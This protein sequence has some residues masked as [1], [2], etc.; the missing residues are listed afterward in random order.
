MKKISNLYNFLVFGGAL[1]IAGAIAAGPIGTGIGDYVISNQV[2]GDTLVKRKG[3]CE[4]SFRA[5]SIEPTP[6]MMNG[7]MLEKKRGFESASNAHKTVRA[8]SYGGLLILAPI[9]FFAYRR[10]RKPE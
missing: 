3:L 9:T 8:I 2:H 7:C 4:A 5:M 10:S 1:G 6:D